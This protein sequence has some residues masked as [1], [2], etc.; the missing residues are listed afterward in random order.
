ML[1]NF[2]AIYL[3]YNM[4][5]ICCNSC[6]AKTC[7]KYIHLFKLVSMNETFIWLLRWIMASALFKILYTSSTFTNIT[8]LFISTFVVLHQSNVFFFFH[9]SFFK[10]NHFLLLFYF[11]AS[12]EQLIFYFQKQELSCLSRVHFWIYWLANLITS[13]ILIGSFK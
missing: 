5:A 4:Y 12:N 11:C 3:T 6:E 2:S 9:I 7:L 8:I 10:I 1:R 13:L